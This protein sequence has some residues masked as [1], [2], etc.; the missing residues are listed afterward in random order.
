M[1]EK[2]YTPKHIAKLMVSLIPRSKPSI[3]TDICVGSWNLLSEAQKK[4][5]N[6]ILHGV[7]VEIKSSVKVLSN[8]QFFH[9]DGRQF[10]I[11]C[12]SENVKYPLILANPPFGKDEKEHHSACSALP[13][14]KYVGERAL[15]RIETTMLLANIAILSDGGYLVAIVPRTLID[16][17]W[18]N[19]LRQ[20]ISST[21]QLKSIVH[22]PPK[23]FGKEIRTSIIVICKS[24]QLSLRAYVYDATLFND[25]EFSLTIQG[26]IEPKFLKE[27]I[28]TQ[29]KECFSQNEGLNLI[30][31]SIKSDNIKQFGLHP[32]I[33]S[34]DISNL[35]QGIWKPANFCS[36]IPG[37]PATKFTSDGD[38]LIIRVGRN[39]G[40]AA[41]I[42]GGTSSL[43]T[44]C[45]LVIRHNS[46][47]QMERIWKLLNSKDYLK[48][49]EILRKGVSASYITAENLK[50]YISFKLNG[51]DYFDYNEA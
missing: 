3:V 21:F 29:A 35:R 40:T 4:W 34:T 1:W 13:G 49:L 28:W 8:S 2:Y 22:L 12:L 26:N 44:D 46:P 33:H 11:K 50:Q 32:V 43:F 25:K 18:G 30:R 15:S 5:R 17:N 16:G 23:A 42:S 48:D 19:K 14:Y 9:M 20:F 6:V 39:C 27:G 24:P 7:D 10:A 45:I 51:G 47:K 38:I 37:D 31:G 36:Q 41:R